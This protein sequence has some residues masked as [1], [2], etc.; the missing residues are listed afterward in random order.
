MNFNFYIRIIFFIYLWILYRE[1]L[2]RDIFLRLIMDKLDF[3][4]YKYCMFCIICE[5]KFLNEIFSFIL[6]Y[7]YVFCN[8]NRWR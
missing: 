5:I 6:W 3:F 2:F 8:L 7:M 4:F 1:K